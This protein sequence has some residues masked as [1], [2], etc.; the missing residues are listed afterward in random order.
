MT[1]TA[2]TLKLIPA[3][4]LG[5]AIERMHKRGQSL[6]ADMHRIAC[7]T[8]AHLA[9]FKDVRMVLACIN[10]MPEMAR[11]NGL[12][13]WFEA[14]GPVKFTEEEG[15]PMQA[16]FI[17]GGKFKLGDAMSKPFWKFSAKEGAPYEPLD[18]DKLTLQTIAKLTKDAKE[19][20]RD[21]TALINAL[22]G[23]NIPAPVNAD[24]LAQTN[25]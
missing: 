9:E 22:K 25:V 21:H 4:K 6:Q 18:I 7:S 8:L 13:A 19:T 2:V 24:P 23:Y 1:K 20:G 15:V 5:A 16:M 10:G 12:K 11:T 3:D 17:K 14:F